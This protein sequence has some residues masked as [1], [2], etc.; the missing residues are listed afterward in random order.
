MTVFL[1]GLEL[2]FF[3]EDIVLEPIGSLFYNKPVTCHDSCF[4][5]SFFVSDD[6]SA[7]KTLEEVLSGE[8]FEGAEIP[9]KWAILSNDNQSGIYIDYH[10]DPQLKKVFGLIDFEK[11]SIKTTLV[12]GKEGEVITLDPLFQPFGSILMVVLAHYQN[13]ILIH[14]SGVNDGGIG[15]LFTAVS[16]TGKSTMAALWKEAGADVV[17]DDRLWLH[18]IAGKWHF[19]NTPMPYYAQKP[20]M[21]PLDEIFLIR[22]S[23]QNV[24]KKL[25]GVNAAMRFMANGIQ[26]FYDKEMT[27]RHLDRVLDIAKQTPIYDCGFL[28]TGEIVETIRGLRIGR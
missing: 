19:F 8:S 2:V 17:N 6:L 20:A 11:K 14:A 25:S 21:A 9:Y 26:H 3:S 1:P 13:D 18:Q 10:E 7:C 12:P 24:I 5:C 15:R 27:G 4:N 22:Q 23:A 16:G 28:P